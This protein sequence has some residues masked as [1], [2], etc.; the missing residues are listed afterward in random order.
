MNIIQ[1][2]NII[3]KGNI[4]IQFYLYCVKK[5]FKL[6]RFIFINIWLFIISCFFNSK[7]N[8][9]T[10]KKYEYLNY[11][12]NLDKLLNDF[13]KKK[14]IN[15]YY[16]FDYEVII[17]K[18]PIIFIKK[19]IKNKKVIGYEFD[20][21]YN[22]LLNDYNKELDK[23]KECNKIY[24]RSIFNLINIKPKDNYIVFNKRIKYTRKY[25]YNEKII[26][27]FLMLILA[28][29][30]TSYSFLYTNTVVD[31]RFLCSY[32]EFNVFIIN[33]SIVLL[34]MILIYLITKR[35][36]ISWIISS[37]LV[38]ILGIA[39]QTKLL[40]RDDIV[41]F[42]DL[43]LLKEAGIMS[44]KYSIVFKWYSIIL[45]CII[46]FIFMLL[47]KYLVVKK[48]KLKGQ[49]IE[50][51]MCIII[52][53][54]SYKMY[55]TD[56]SIYLSLGDKTLI[57]VWVITQNYQIRGLVYPFVYTL[58]DGF[59]KAPDGYDKTN[60]KEIIEKYKYEDIDNNKKVNI[61]AI[62]LEA[63]NDFSKFDKIDFNI[64]VYDNLH[65]IQDKSISGNIV[66]N[67]FGG[68]TI[69][70]ERNFL[71]GYR[72]FPIFRKPTNSY[73]W[74]FKE[75]G[76]N[77]EALHPI[78][79]AFY[80]RSG[81][82]PNLGFNIYYNYDN[83]FKELDENYRQDEFFMDYIIKKYEDNKETNN[84]YFSFSVTY[85]N[86]GPYDS[87][88]YEGKKY[89]FDNDGRYDDETYN[90]I[91]EYLNG[92]YSTNE[93]LANLINYFDNEDEPVIII[94]FGDHN[95]YIGEN[96]FSE[97]G[98]NMD[99]GTVE[100]FLNYYETPYVIHANDSAKEMFGK[101]FVGDGN[102]ISPIF[103]MNELFDYCGLEGNEYLQYMSNLKKKIDVISDYY[104]KEN[105]EFIRVEDSNNQD[106]VDE[107]NQVSYYMANNK[108]NR[109]D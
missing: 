64:D 7:K 96:G 62:M 19:F 3:Y 23:I 98:V 44:E 33:Y 77:T 30:I 29:I 86:H 38:L 16:D 14:K 55:Y 39:N 11:V 67:I 82:N 100:G 51:F 63:Y 37:L 76:Y 80:N 72:M 2:N 89:Y 108:I 94:F 85:Q 109:K 13:S 66:T 9:Y 26:R 34:I 60:S 53:F 65:E 21:K 24:K 106:I 90:I 22:I 6:I 36:H 84:P 61:I 17:D 56:Y 73:V 28:F 50:L 88:Y 78:Y 42:E 1:F 87:N 104:Y 102:K 20:S 41:K 5:D 69:N 15:N 74:Y 52:I 43:S 40:Y 47:K 68:G 92:I 8:L 10:I 99:L 32:F 35:F 103:L 48:I 105:G 27:T 46:L 95:P 12:K 4:N 97:M 54:G 49:I 93:S 107:Y 57:N 71:T 45:I 58:E 70:T 18:V 31:K 101:T 81:T 59:I 25:R 79:G 75:Q 91:N 83:T